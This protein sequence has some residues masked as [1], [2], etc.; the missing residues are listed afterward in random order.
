MADTDT[1]RWQRARAIFDEVVDLEPAARAARLDDLCK[2]DDALRREVES[3]LEHDLPSDDAISQ[4]VAEAARD[5]ADE[6]TALRPGQA[7]LHYDLTW[8]IGQGGMGEVWKATDHTLGREVAIKILP[9][10]FAKDASRLA[11]F[12]RE[13]KLLAALNHANIAAV[14]SLH[15]DARV[16]FLAMEYVEGEDLSDR[17]ARGAIPIGQLLPIARQIAEAL[18]EAHEKGIIHRDLKPANVK[19]KPDGRVKVLDFGLAKALGDEAASIARPTH[20]PRRAVR[21]VGRRATPAHGS[22]SSWAPPPTC[23]RSRPA[24]SRSTSAP[25]SGPSASILF[26]MLSG[27]RPFAGATLTDVLAAVVTAEPDWSVLPATTPRALV[28]LIRRCLE[29]DARQRLRD[30]GDARFEIEQLIAEHADSGSGTTRAAFAGAARAVA[31]ARGRD[32][33]AGRRGRGTRGVARDEAGANG[34]PSSG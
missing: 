28:R 14:Y 29:K 11:R 25:T 12:A 20:R 3:L 26:E 13:A 31:L 18:E 32:V 34:L 19:L 6:G 24:A 9:A 23:P 7:L 8:K 33:P 15:Q 22:A 5:A 27:R 21:P 30:I 2:D 4:V 10:G 16:P 17:L 1:A